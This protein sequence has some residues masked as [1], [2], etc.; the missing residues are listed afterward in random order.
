MVW[1]IYF[2]AANRKR[3]K[4]IIIFKK[5]YQF[6]HLW[7][8]IMKE[9]FKHM[10]WF[11]STVGNE[12]LTGN[13]PLYSAFLRLTVS[14]QT[15]LKWS[16]VFWH[17]IGATNFL[18]NNWQRTRLVAGMI[19]FHVTNQSVFFQPGLNSCLVFVLSLTC[20]FSLCNHL[21][22]GQLYYLFPT[23]EA[24]CLYVWAYPVL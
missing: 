9:S 1:D 20:K 10:Q 12:T 24:T 18:Q 19:S 16:L 11:M 13:C 2:S 15:I 22:S 21:L 17:F 3:K 8:R 7:K 6:T 5:G 4:K 14:K 23:G